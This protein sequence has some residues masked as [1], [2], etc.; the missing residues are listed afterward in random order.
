MEAPAGIGEAVLG[1]V[2]F[3]TERFLRDEA[4]HDR[5]EEVLAHLGTAAAVSRVYLFQNTRGPDGRLWMDLRFE[6][7]ADG[8]R[9]VFDDPANHLHPYAPD[10]SRWI[11]VLGRRGEVCALVRGLPEGERRVLSGEGV[12]SVLAVPV[13]V[14]TDWWGFLG[15]DDT[16]ARGWSEVETG[17]LRA[18]AGALGAAIERQRGEETLR[19]AEQQY[20]SIVEHIPAITYIDAVN[21][22][23]A[24]VYVS[25]QIE[26]VLGYSQQEW[27]ADRDLWPKILHPDDRA[28]ALAENARHNEAGEPFALEY[29]MFAKDGRVVWVLDR[30]SLVRDEHGAPLFSHGVMLDISERKR[31]EDQVAFLAYHDELTGL[32]SRSMFEEL[33]SLSIDRAR[34]HDGSVAVVCLD[35]DDFRLVNDSL[36]H[37]HGD[38]LLKMVA[39]RLRGSTRETDLVARR[40]GDQFLLL[41]ADL[42]REERGDA[43]APMIRAES[44]VRHIHESLTSPFVVAGTELY[45]SASMGISLFPQDGGEPGGLL[46]NAE[47]AM[48]QSKKSGPAG[49]VVSAR[50]SADPSA[51]L[52]FVT[53]LRKAVENRRWVLHYQPVIELSTGG[54]VGVEGLIRWVEPDGTLIPPG[55]FIPLAEELGLIESI[56]EWVVNEIVYQARA[57]LDLGIDLEIGFN[58][59]PRQFWQPDLAGKI[60]SQITD[61]GVD[62]ARIVVEVTES[63]A[64][65]DPDRAQEILWELHRGGLRIAIDDFGTGYSSLSRLRAVPIDRLKIDRSFVSGVDL[66]PQAAS[67]VTAFIELAMGL[68]M[69]TLAEGIETRGELDLLVARGCQMGQGYLFSRPVPPEE[70]IAFALGGVPVATRSG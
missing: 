43:D 24:A 38:D 27:L 30:A 66:D 65:I 23:A 12:G 35:L 2:A 7:E 22:R 62:P 11:E 40:G 19:F 9:R 31:D 15:F 16:C 54:M 18:T 32:P 69:T 70:I 53:R 45:I 52:R 37:H 44:V 8:V 58:L 67:I 68:G 25:P 21:E 34:R 14:G 60:L 29:R 56:G 3:A 4:W 61:G 55:D 42:E 41:L 51:K 20:R 63:S 59:S 28:R 48:Y 39:D 10:F 57:W 33:L 1:A 13:F 47:A 36:G 46:R 26:R 6:W 49:Y 50:G 17:A 5:I 64:M